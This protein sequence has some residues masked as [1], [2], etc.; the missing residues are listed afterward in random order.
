[1]SK[2]KQCNVRIADDTMICPLC[3]RVLS[4][5][6][7]KEKSAIK[8]R[9]EPMGYPD[10]KEKAKRFQKAGRILCFAALVLEAMMILI[11]YLTFSAIP[12]YWS[13]IFG[14]VLGYVTITLWDLVRRRQGHIRKIYMH[15][16]N[17]LLL[18]ILIDVV[19]GWRGW[20]L[21]F[22]LPCIIYSLVLVIITCMIVNSSSWHNYVLMQL[23]AILLSVIDVGLHFAGVFHHIILAWIALG[24]SVLLWS[25]T[26]IIGD[27]KARNELKRKLHV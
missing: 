8:N 15:V 2:C 23:A 22:G 10:I 19:L 18:L 20:S 17:V 6:S 21:E 13:V 26:M 24:I 3:H 9:I 7:P 27:R 16:F 12:K 11:N 5:E 1:M 25:G 14:A 4:E